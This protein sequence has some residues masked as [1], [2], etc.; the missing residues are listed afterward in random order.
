MEPPASTGAAAE[1]GAR[2]I[3]DGF[4]PLAFLFAPLWLAW[5]RLWLEAAL[6]LVAAMAI[7]A[8]TAA[9]GL[10]SAGSALS[11]LLSVFIGLEAQNWRIAKLRRRDWREW[12]AVEASDI[13][14]AEMRYA[15][16]REEED[17][18][19]PKDAAPAPAPDPFAA[20]AAA[21]QPALGML[22][23]PTRH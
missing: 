13:A 7:G 22:A 11:L 17:E 9:A 16:A 8:G 3:K 14:E 18:S 4:T 19:A 20:R 21:I 23:Y 12:G 1:E 6:Y 15:I 10:G 5:H 2:F